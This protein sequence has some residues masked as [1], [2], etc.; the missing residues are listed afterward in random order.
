[1]LSSIHLKHLSI[2][3]S[4]W[5][6]KISTFV[7]M[8]RFRATG[9]KLEGPSQDQQCKKS[10]LFP[11]LAPIVAIVLLTLFYLWTLVQCIC[12][13][14]NVYLYKYYKHISVFYLVNKLGDHGT[15]PSLWCGRGW[16]CKICIGFCLFYGCF[17]SKH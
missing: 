5:S 15:L 10:F 17:I 2:R 12:C 1:M 14:L 7:H 6:C 9:P 3:F 8:D 11:P 13:N 16:R 4:T